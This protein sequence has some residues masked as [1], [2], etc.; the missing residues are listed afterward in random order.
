MAR[1]EET[2]REA[3]TAAVRGAVDLLPPR[4]LP[5]PGSDAEGTRG[6]AG[7]PKPESHPPVQCPRVL[8]G[9]AQ[10]SSHG[11]GSSLGRWSRFSITLAWG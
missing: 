1:G 10:D 2:R 11:G 5:S 9:E 6:E 7:S 8:H 4:A 3:L